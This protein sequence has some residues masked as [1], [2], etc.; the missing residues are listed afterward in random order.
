M[1]QELGLR[2]TPSF[3]A[4]SPA[5]A[6]VIVKKTDELDRVPDVREARQQNVNLLLKQVQ[7]LQQALA[8]S[9]A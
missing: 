9:S 2:D 5:Q 3:G 1:E 6:H 8:T 4:K 7:Q